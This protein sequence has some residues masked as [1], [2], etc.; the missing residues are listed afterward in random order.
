MSTSSASAAGAGRRAIVPAVHQEPHRGAVRRLGA[1]HQRPGRTTPGQLSSSGRVGQPRGVAVRRRVAAAGRR[2][3][4]VTCGMSTASTTTRLVAPRRGR[5]RPPP[6]RPAARRPAGPRGR[7]VTGAARRASP[8]PPRRPPRRRP[9]RPARARA[10]SGRR[11]R[12]R[13]CRRRPGA[14][15]VP[16]V[17]ITAAH[18]TPPWCRPW[19]GG[20][21]AGAMQVVLVQE[22]SSLD[23]ADNRARLASVVPDGRRPR[24]APRGVR[25]RLR[26][27]RLR[28]GAVRRAAGRPVRHR[29]RAGRAASGA[30][31]S[32]RACSSERRGRARRTTPSWCAAAPGSTT[33][34]STSTTRSA[35]RS[36]KVLAAGPIEPATFDLGGHDASA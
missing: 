33:A 27:A 9:P 3:R 34:R 24:R 11:A 28:P 18:V 15:A 16:P 20:W 8:A 2:C 5:R 23:P 32:S 22:A 1:G 7:T 10:A 29:G 21:Q 17:R 31:R 36:P 25:P 4:R 26:R 19:Y 30:P 12:G 13:P 35:T 14:R 6:A